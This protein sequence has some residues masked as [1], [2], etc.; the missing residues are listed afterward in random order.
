MI[1][2]FTQ[3]HLKLLKR[4][5]QALSNLAL[6]SKLNL[7]LKLRAKVGRHRMILMIKAVYLLLLQI[8]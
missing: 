2:K 5:Y 8:C 7:Q 4:M 3:S 6:K 1:N